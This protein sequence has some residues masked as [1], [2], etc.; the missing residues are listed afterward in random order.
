[1][2]QIMSTVHSPIERMQSLGNTQL[3]R[4]LQTNSSVRDLLS[5]LLRVLSADVFQ[6]SRLLGF[7]KLQRVILSKDKPH[8]GQPIFKDQSMWGCGV[9]LPYQ[10]RGQCQKPS[11]FSK[12]PMGSTKVRRNLSL[13][14]LI[15][16]PA[17]TGIDSK[18]L[19]EQISCTLNSMSV[20]FLR[21]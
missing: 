3:Q 11:Q 5:W 21:N 12:T 2:T 14:T 18:D 10:N 7:A 13:T 1:M 9:Y 19:P 16:F 17:S 15:S 6:L 4:T 8:L 20:S